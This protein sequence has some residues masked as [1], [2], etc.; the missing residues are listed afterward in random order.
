MPMSN[1]QNF[2]SDISAIEDIADIDQE[3]GILL[4]EF[5]STFG[6]DETYSPFLFA[7]NQITAQTVDN[8]F[9]RLQNQ[10]SLDNNPGNL[11]VIVD[12]SGGDLDAAYNL[13]LLFQRYGHKHLTYVVPRWAKSAATLLVCG[14]NSIMMTPVAELG[15]LDPQITQTNYLE[16]RRESFSPLHIESTL[17][18]IRNEFAQGHRDLAKGLLQRL[19]FPITLGRFKQSLE[20]GK[21]YANNLLSSR[22]LK[23]DEESA[24]LIAIQLVED[25]ANHG[26]CINI[27]EAKDLGLAV[28]DLSPSQIRLVWQIHKLIRW[29]SELPKT[30]SRQDTPEQPEKLPPALPLLDTPPREIVHPE[31]S[32]NSQDDD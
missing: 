20:I 4:D 31:P 30:Q 32:P 10:F 14:G 17:E 21:Q 6:Y 1:H 28:H 13:A 18:L 7:E 26:F 29:K 23:N 3:I 11:I 16:R 24:H 27:D 15:P 12:S 22:M 19:Q 5:V 2:S 8:V 9:D 25:Y